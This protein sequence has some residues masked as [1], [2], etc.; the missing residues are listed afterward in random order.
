MG[1]FKI[2][3]LWPNPVGDVL[4][5]KLNQSLQQAE[6]EITDINGTVVRKLQQLTGINPSKIP[7]ENL[8]AGIY[9]IKIKTKDGASHSDKFVKP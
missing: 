6:Y 2:N 7:V 9:L 4:N 1:D 8:P 5:I 3:G